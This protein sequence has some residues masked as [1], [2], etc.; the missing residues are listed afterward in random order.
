LCRPVG[1]Q[2]EGCVSHALSFYQYSFRVRILGIVLIYEVLLGT[3]V[4]DVQVTVHRDKFL[5]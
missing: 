5:K 2:V 1:G 3:R 4:F